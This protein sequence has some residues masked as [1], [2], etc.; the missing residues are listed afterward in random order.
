MTQYSLNQRQALAA[1]T[2]LSCSNLGSH[3][4]IQKHTDP[5]TNF[6]DFEAMIDFRWSSG[7][8]TLLA[9]LKTIVTQYGEIDYRGILNLDETNRGAVGLALEIGLGLREV[10]V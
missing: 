1:R 7:E 4:I 10:T 5:D 2:L 3:P 6:Y 9:I 8:I